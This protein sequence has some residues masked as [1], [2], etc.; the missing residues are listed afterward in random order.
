MC[1]TCPT[2][3]TLLSVTLGMLDEKLYVLPWSLVESNEYRVIIKLS[4]ILQIM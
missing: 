2:R 3:V 1:A 4:I